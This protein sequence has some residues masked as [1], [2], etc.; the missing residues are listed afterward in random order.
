MQRSS[1]SAAGYQHPDVTLILPILHSHF[2]LNKSV[3]NETIAFPLL[4]SWGCFSESTSLPTQGRDA[5]A[6]H[7]SG[8]IASAAF[9]ALGHCS[10]DELAS[11]E[12]SKEKSGHLQ[13]QK[14]W[15]PSWVAR[16][17]PSFVELPRCAFPPLPLHHPS[18]PSG[19]GFWCSK[20]WLTTHL[21]KET[22]TLERLRKLQ[23]KPKSTRTKTF[24]HTPSPA[25]HRSPCLEEVVTNWPRQIQERWILQMRLSW[26]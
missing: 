5:A 16:L 21:V 9:K 8:V 13:T 25:L 1:K 20:R 23:P 6:P 17:A 11:G 12:I 24:K 10:P 22:T 3:D 26:E 2:A 4:L 15:L 19:R 7:E 14:I 18:D